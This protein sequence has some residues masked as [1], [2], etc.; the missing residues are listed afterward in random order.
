MQHSVKNERL[1]SPALSDVTGVMVQERSP[2]MKKRS[3]GPVTAAGRCRDLR[4]SFVLVPHAL[5][6]VVQ[7]K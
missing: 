4:G 1:K 7:V 6:V 2:V 3:A 5:I